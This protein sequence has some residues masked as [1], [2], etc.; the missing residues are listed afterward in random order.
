MCAGAKGVRVT[1]TPS[2]LGVA[3]SVAG[4]LDGDGQPDLAVGLPGRDNGKVRFAVGPTSNHHILH[5]LPCNPAHSP[6]HPTKNLQR[7]VMHQSLAQSA[8]P[9]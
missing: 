3:L 4:D 7:R 8:R 1:P 5:I 6:Q 2:Q 9:H